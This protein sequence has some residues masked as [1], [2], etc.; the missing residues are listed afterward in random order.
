MRKADRHLLIKQIITSHSIRTQEDLL[1]Q[2]K[3]QG[4]TAT[5]ATISRDIRDLQIV[6]T[7]D[8]EG[9][10][11][12][13][14]FQGTTYNENEKVE[15]EERLIQMIKDIV[16]KVQ[17]VHFLTIVS[18]LPDNAH[19]LASIIDELKPPY[20]VSTI[21]GFDTVVII[22][23]SDEEAEKMEAYFTEHSL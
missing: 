22:S 1:Q 10:P 4:V 7:T 11:I 2:L 8:E 23:G 20:V 15:E 3:N 9:L 18:T 17:R 13:Q 21:A 19:L 14:I 6:K 12:F 16:T 5:Q